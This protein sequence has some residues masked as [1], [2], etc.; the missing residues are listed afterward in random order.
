MSGR[1]REGGQR[2]SGIEGS[3]KE[4]A[5]EDGQKFLVSTD[6]KEEENER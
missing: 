6:K 2:E 3:K 1:K 4:E 5:M